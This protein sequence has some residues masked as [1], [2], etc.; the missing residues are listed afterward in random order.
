MTERT[1]IGFRQRIQL[2]WLNR[3]ALL[4]LSGTAKS[5]IRAELDTYLQNYLSIGSNA[6][7]GNRAI[8]IYILLKV[9]V[10]VPEQVKG[11]RDDGLVLFKQ[12]APQDRLVI[13]WGMLMAVY[14]FFRAVA[15]TVGRLQRLQGKVVAAQVQRRMREQLGE[16]SA[17]E[18]A[19][20]RTLRCF[21]DWGV[22]RETPEKGVYV[23]APVIPVDDVELVGWLIEA[24]LLA[25]ES[26]SGSLHALLKNPALFP[27]EIKTI[28]RNVLHSRS[29]LELFQQGVDEQVVLLRGR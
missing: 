17:V 27:F 13:H 8:A 25:Q 2:E 1:E 22:L 14:P 16:R 5:T 7:A 3:T 6:R 10:T 4:Y 24:S 28:G 19:T 9:W 18:R 23:L 20:R 15:E 21:I 29:R 11:L 26:S 12:H